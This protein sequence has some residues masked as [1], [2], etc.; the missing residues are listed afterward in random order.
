MGT[1]KG[2]KLK[3]REWLVTAYSEECSGPGW[4]NMPVIVIIQDSL[5]RM[6]QEYLQPEDQTEEIRL[7]YKISQHVNMAM[8][9]AV[10]KVL[11][12]G[13]R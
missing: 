5:G 8:K 13:K 9:Y 7:L 6:R 2:L 4:A 10:G 11:K 12:K 3:A 1:A